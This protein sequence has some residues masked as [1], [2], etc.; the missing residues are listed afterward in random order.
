MQRFGEDGRRDPKR[1]MDVWDGFM[2]L[3][4]ADKIRPVTY[5]EDYRGLEA[6]SKALEDVKARKAWG[7]SVVKICEDV[8]V[9]DGQK[10]R[11]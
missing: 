7:R 3:V 6:V 5:K 4:E 10:A 8:E 1:T 11:L 9:G 2:T